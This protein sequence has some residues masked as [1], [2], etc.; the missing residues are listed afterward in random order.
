VF[1]YDGTHPVNVIHVLAAFVAVQLVLV[2]LFVVSRLPRGVTRFVP[3]MQTVQE[4]LGLFSPGRLQRLMARYL[5]QSYRE[6]AA[7][8]L[9][10]G[11]AHQRLYGHVDR[12][13]IAHSSQIFALAFNVGAVAG[14]LYLVVFSDLAFSWNTTLQLEPTE[15]KRW[16][17]ALSVP[18][19][20][21]FGD[22][23]P[24][25]DLIE[26]TRYFRLKEGAFPNAAS[27]ASLGGWWPFLVMCMVIYG[28]VPRLI[29]WAVAGQRL[30]ANL[31]RTFLRFP[32][33]AELLERLNTEL[34]ETRAEEP[35]HAT[36]V[37]SGAGAAMEST[38]GVA[39]RATL[40]IDWAATVAE[41][42]AFAAWLVGTAGVEIA[43]WEKA[44]GAGTLEQDHATVN[45]AADSDFG[46]MVLVKAW[47]PPMEEVLD[48]LRELRA[49]LPDDRLIHVAPVGWT[50]DGSPCAPEPHHL[51][52][53]QNV[54]ARLGDPWLR[55]TRLE[56]DP[57]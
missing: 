43:V 29:T 10:R 37:E 22:G 33:S 15:M 41:R 1:F 53:W 49:A 36:M 48:F 13:V 42:G 26:N 21:V 8:L 32:D 6:T 50:D 5:P 27:P 44:G 4:S 55:I 38:A 28:L 56:S 20:A 11:R 31:R 57:S 54:L 25:L 12:W 39:G 16:T 3:G 2:L 14:A 35:D 51:Q 19:A 17:D 24:S 23:R 9:G 40:A 52:M 47:E 46:L 45:A 18:W 34:V 7:S 30:R